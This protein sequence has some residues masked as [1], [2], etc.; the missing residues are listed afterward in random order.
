VKVVHGGERLRDR[1]GRGFRGLSSSAV[2]IRAAVGANTS[3]PWNVSL[4][5]SPTSTTNASIFSSCSFSL[6]SARAGGIA[7]PLSGATST[8]EPARTT[9][10][11]RSV[12]TPGSIT[13]QW[14]AGGNSGSTKRSQKAA[15]RGHRG[16]IVGDI[17]QFGVGVAANYSLHRGGVRR[18]EVGGERDHERSAVRLALKKLVGRVAVDSEDGSEDGS[19]VA[20]RWQRGWQRGGSE[21]GS[22]VAARIETRDRQ[23]RVGGRGT[24]RVGL[25]DP[26]DALDA[27]DLLDHVD[28]GLG[29]QRPPVAAVD[30]ALARLRSLQH[31]AT[32][33]RGAASLDAGFLEQPDDERVVRYAIS[34]RGVML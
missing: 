30:H 10:A 28:D 23:L 18:A 15:A 12:P 33:H 22:E 32:E 16:Q 14:T 17:D 4:A 25:R 20:A 26:A 19:E 31:V 29:N 7:S 13:A 1:L 34:N 21:D 5:G 2:R 27:V 11:S 3:R 9:S 24:V 8:C 6:A